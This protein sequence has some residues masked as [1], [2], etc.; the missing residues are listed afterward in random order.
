MLKKQTL[1]TAVLLLFVLLAFGS[2]DSSTSS[3]TSSSGSSGGAVSVISV[4]AE[5]LLAE[6]KANEI[7]A[8]EKYK[9]KAIEVT[10]TIEN[11]GKDILDN[12]YVALK[13]GEQ[14]DFRSVQCFLGENLRKEAAS[15][16]KGSRITVRGECAGMM[17]TIQINDCEFVK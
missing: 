13:S 8:D 1:S 17:G 10:G 9:G 5:Q 7:A 11:I 2:T 12:M 6:Y 16:S 14:Y 4:S 15:L 3:S